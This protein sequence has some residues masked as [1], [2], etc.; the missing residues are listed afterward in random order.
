M[1][2]PSRHRAPSISGEAEAVLVRV[3]QQRASALGAH[4][5]AV[6]RLAVRVGRRLGITGSELNE[7]RRAAELH[8]IGKVAIP[9]PMLEKRGP[10]D[11]EEWELMR[12]HTVLGEQ[13]LSAAPSLA[14]ICK[15][16]RS[17]HERWDGAGYPDGLAEE[18]IPLASRII[19][20]CDAYDAMRCERHYAEAMSHEAALE[21]LRLGAGSQFDP[22]VVDVF[23]ELDESDPD[24]EPSTRRFARVELSPS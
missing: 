7:L 11:A 6:A 22:T 17:S 13:I 5:D 24:A 18:Q 1:R 8:D 21:Q 20:V 16:V 4:G 2:D 15:L 10:L 19:F 14:A 3:Q 12:Q 9:D 23:V